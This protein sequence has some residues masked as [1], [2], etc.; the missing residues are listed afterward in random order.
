MK[1]ATEGLHAAVRVH[2]ALGHAGG[3]AGGQQRDDV[4]H[5]DRQVRPRRRL[6]LDPVDQRA[7]ARDSGSSPSMQTHSLILG[8][9]GRSCG[10]R[11]TRSTSGRTALRS[12]RRRARSDSRRP[13]CA[14]RPESR[15]C[16]RA[17]DPSVQVQAVTSLPAQTAPLSPRPKPAASRPL[18]MRQRQFTDLVEAVA[19]LVLDVGGALGLMRQPR[20]KKS[21]IAMVRSVR[22]R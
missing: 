5:V 10:D 15:P 4:V 13:S 1:W 21:M 3:A 9:R 12:R 7:G 6:V 19:A 18:A 20:S 22:A 2:H 14:H 8:R 11:P 17:T 16:S